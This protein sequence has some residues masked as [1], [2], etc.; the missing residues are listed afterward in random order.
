[1]AP[2]R[3]VTIA[4]AASLALV[5][6]DRTEANRERAIADSRPVSF[7]SADGVTLAGRRF[8]PRDAQVGV[9]LSHM[10]PADQRSWYPLADALGDRG[11]LALTYDFRGY[12]P[13][14][15]G[16]CSQGEKDLSATVRDLA[17]A[18]A[19][20]REQGVQE[21]VLIGASMGGTASL[22]YAASE[23]GEVAAVVAV[24]APTSI[25]GISVGPDT[26][27]GILGAKLFIAGHDDGSAAAD[28]QAFYNSGPPPKRVEILTTGDH[29]TEIF[30]GAQGSR[31]QNL[32]LTWLA[33]VAPASGPG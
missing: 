24:S 11:Y 28:A 18:V 1:V 10:R 12:C 14:G 2:A 22:A 4:V 26:I 3:L 23:P 17:G 13:G 33:Q 27:G 9:V 15:D 30:E 20:V 8:G 5:A 31:A 25:G 32:V 21:I 7:K 16:G 19:F 6:C 29:G